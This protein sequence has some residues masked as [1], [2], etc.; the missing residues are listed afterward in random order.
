MESTMLFKSL[1]IATA[2]NSAS[3]SEESKPVTIRLTD[4]EIQLYDAV[5]KSMGLTRQDFLAHLIRNN[6]KSALQDFLIGYTESSP[7]VSLC[8]L[9]HSNTDSE[10]VKQKVSWLLRS[11]SE[12]LMELDEK[13]IHEHL[14]NQGFNYQ[15]ATP[16]SGIFNDKSG[17]DK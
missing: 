14:E 11:I 15:Y 16:R 17:G 8:E 12:D 7:S 6:F 1:G 5:S 4:S 10:A 3:N 13:S 9:I 2:T